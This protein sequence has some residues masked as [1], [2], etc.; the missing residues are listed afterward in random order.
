MSYDVRHY[1]LPEDASAAD[2]LTLWAWKAWA[3]WLRP[4]LLA[5][6]LMTVVSIIVGTF[7][8]KSTGYVGKWSPANYAP[9]APVGGDSLAELNGAAWT[10]G[11]LAQFASVAAATVVVWFVLR[12]APRPAMVGAISGLVV[13]GLHLTFSHQWGFQPIVAAPSG[14]QAAALVSLWMLPIVTAAL[15]AVVDRRRGPDDQQR[16]P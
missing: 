7:I 1:R 16:H 14:Y 13:V 5:T 9:A 12:R 8:A 10:R 2:R 4:L 11:I 15:G 6:I 3:T